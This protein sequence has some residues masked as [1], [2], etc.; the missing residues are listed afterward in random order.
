MNIIKQ[1]K[2]KPISTLITIFSL[3]GMIVTSALYIEDRFAHQRDLDELQVQVVVL[4]EEYQRTSGKV[5]DILKNQAISRK[6]I[7][8][9]REANGTIT[10]EETVEL[11]NLKE[12]LQD[13]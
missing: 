5:L 11:I 3:V 4:K 13:I 9:L 7:L 10:A 2:E 12:T 8:E 1:I 6:T